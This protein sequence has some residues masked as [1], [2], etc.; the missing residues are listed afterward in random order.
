MVLEE[1]TPDLLALL[2]TYAGGNTLVVPV[3]TWPPTPAPIHTSVVDAPKKKRKKGKTTKGSKE[4]EIPQPS[5][6]PP[7]KEPR[8]TRAQQKKGTSFEA[9]KCTEGEQCS[10]AFIWNLAL[11]LSSGDPVTND[12]SL[13]DPK[14]GRLE[15]VFKCL[16]KALLLP[17]DMQEL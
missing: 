17:R 9:S 7:A 15:L 1:K 4:R 6:Q 13:K 2:T 5:Q 10:K 11:V 14:K 3:V 12:V 16:E 8:V